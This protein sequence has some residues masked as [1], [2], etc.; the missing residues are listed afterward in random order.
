MPRR[1][2]RRAL[3]ANAKKAMPIVR[4]HLTAAERMQSGGGMNHRGM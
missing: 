4:S 3:R 1:V 2:T